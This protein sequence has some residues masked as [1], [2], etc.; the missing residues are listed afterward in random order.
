[1]AGLRSLVLRAVQKNK[2]MGVLMPIA[3]FLMLVGCYLVG[4]YMTNYIGDIPASVIG[5]IVLFT[6]LMLLRRVPE[7]VETM[8][9][10]LLKYL[11]LMLVVP[12]VGI[13]DF[14]GLEASVWLRLVLVVALSLLV[15][16]PLCG[17]LLQ[18]LIGR[19]IDHV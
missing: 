10:N 2:V 6:L 11:P 4:A 9:G 15:T 19:R 8:A 12:A 5:I 18:Y 7:G 17:W 16:V 1:M 3:G 13:V 14:S